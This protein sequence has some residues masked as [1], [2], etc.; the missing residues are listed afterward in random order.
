[1]SGSKRSYD[2]FSKARSEHAAYR[3]S[4]VSYQQNFLNKHDGKIALWNLLN[5]YLKRAS[6]DGWDGPSMSE[7]L[8]ALDFEDPAL[9]DHFVDIRDEFGLPKWR[10]VKDDWGGGDDSGIDIVPTLIE[11]DSYPKLTE[12]DDADDLPSVPNFVAFG[13]TMRKR[14]ERVEKAAMKFIT[15]MKEDG[16]WGYGGKVKF[17]DEFREADY[18]DQVAIVADL[19]AH[20]S[21]THNGRV[22]LAEQFTASDPVFDPVELFDPPKKTTTTQVGITDKERAR[23]FTNTGQLKASANVAVARGLARIAANC[24]PGLFFHYGTV[25]NASPALGELGKFVSAVTTAY[26][27]ANRLSGVDLNKFNQGNVTAADFGTFGTALLGNVDT[28]VQRANEAEDA[29]DTQFAK[30][31]AHLKQA[32][33]SGRV[34]GSVNYVLGLI[35]I[36]SFIVEKL[37]KGQDLKTRDV[38]DLLRAMLTITDIEDIA[39]VMGHGTTRKLRTTAAREGIDIAAAS[40]DEVVKKLNNAGNKGALAAAKRFR[41]IA[42]EILGPILDVVDI[43]WNVIDLRK[44]FQRGDYS[45]AVGYGMLGVSSAT[46]LA[47]TIAKTS[48]GT[49]IMPSVLSTAALGPWAFGIAVVLALVGWGLLAFTTDHPLETFIENSY[50]GSNWD[51]GHEKYNDLTRGAD[52]VFFDWDSSASTNSTS[53]N[54]ERMLSAFFTKLFPVG[55]DEAKVWKGNGKTYAS[56]NAQDVKE[57]HSSSMLTYAPIVPSDRDDDEN[58]Q[59]GD[60]WHRIRTGRRPHR[61]SSLMATQNR[62]Y[63]YEPDGLFVD[64]DDPYPSYAEKSRFQWPEPNFAIGH[65]PH[66]QGINW[67]SG[68]T[69]TAVFKAVFFYPPIGQNS[70]Q[71][72]SNAPAGFD[73]LTYLFGIENLD[74]GTVFVEVAH[75]SADIQGR[76]GKMLQRGDLLTDPAAER[77]AVVP[78][79]QYEITVNL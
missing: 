47:A 78:K 17:K 15:W 53:P 30:L 41:K 72:P 58:Y 9:K 67:S 13:R 26:L 20:L 59:L 42:A 60:P 5:G 12:N 11:D 6:E 63:I 36:T 39:A 27:P 73:P 22:F 50:F 21:Q 76:I 46:M 1:M 71:P 69:M 29:A 33:I 64:I 56:V 77:L 49:A 40:G 35:G 43:V 55:L 75:I 18:V 25:E 45:V 31:K 8:E 14:Q 38:T 74:E 2:T 79:E 37:D 51:P 48:I 57:F 16:D 4:I 65:T 7:L 10:A 24:L 3:R 44:A 52:D 62:Q 66:R 70:V 68:G 54:F 19:T 28:V 32:G 61:S 34:T 23:L